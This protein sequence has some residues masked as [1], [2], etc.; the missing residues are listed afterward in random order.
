[1]HDRAK[2]GDPLDSEVATGMRRQGMDRQT[3]AAGVRNYDRLKRRLEHAAT[4]FLSTQI[5]DAIAVSSSALPLSFQWMNTICATWPAGFMWCERPI[6]RLDAPIE[7]KQIGDLPLV[8]I[9]W[10][11]EA[12]AID[13]WAYA[14]FGNHMMVCGFAQ[15]AEGATADV[16]GGDEHER[17]LRRF[18]MTALLWLEQRIV[19]TTAARAERHVRKRVSSPDA[20]VLI[21]RLRRTEPSAPA[22]PGAG[23]EWSCQWQVRGHWRRQFHPSTGERRPLWIDD[24]WKGP[25]DKP[26]R[27]HDGR[28]VA[29]VR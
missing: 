6:Y 11:V 13:V 16:Q 25:A 20:P 5:A 15:I 12:D 22:R 8:A 19:V 29:A 10:C 21:I 1:M 18:T 3:V 2:R 27:V 4:F 14:Q 9:A 7:A 28:I 24:F 23:V 26:I 17:W